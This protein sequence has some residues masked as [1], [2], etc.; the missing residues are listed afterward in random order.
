MLVM[1]GA[2]HATAAPTP[3]RLSIL[4]RVISPEAWTSLESGIPLLLALDER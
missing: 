4:R 1:I 3:I 2:D